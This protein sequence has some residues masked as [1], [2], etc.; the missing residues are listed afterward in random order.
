MLLGCIALLALNQVIIK[1]TVGGFAPVFQAGLR[2]LGVVVLLLIWMWL[3][4]VPFAVPR[5]AVGWGILSGCFFAHEFLCLYSALD[6]TTVARASIMFYSMPVWLALAGHFLLPGE[7]LTRLRLLGLAVAMGGVVL[8]LADRS[9]EQA[10]L[11]GDALALL[12]TLGWTGIMLTVRATPLSRVSPLIQL[13]FQVSVSS[14]I[15]LGAAPLF[16]ETLRD[17]Q[18]IHWLGLGYQILGVGCVAFLLWFWLMTIY[19]ANA[20]AS[21]SFLTPVL[22]VIFGWLVL[23]EQIGLSAWIALGLVTAGI[24]LINRS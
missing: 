12:G 11:A 23:G 2:S 4:R 10:S 18:P 22:A 20:I 3:R 19:R 15:L 14:V 24:A 21:F 7:R 6:M 9:N 8:A 1:I 16:G 5:E 17:P 13:L